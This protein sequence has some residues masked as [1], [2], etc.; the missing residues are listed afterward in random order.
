MNR[1]RPPNLVRA[2]SGQRA[3]LRPVRLFRLRHPLVQ[4]APQ[5]EMTQVPLQP[6]PSGQFYRVASP[7]EESL[8]TSPLATELGKALEQFAQSNGFSAEQPLSI[9]FKRGTLG[10]HRFGRAADIYAAGGKGIGQWASEWNAAMRQ[11]N[12]ATDPQERARLIEEEKQRNLGYKLYKA[13]QAHGG[14]AQPQSYP[15]QLFGPWTRGEGPHK[16]ISDRLLR[17]HGDHL[18]I[19]K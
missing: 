10:L 19:A 12:A 3:R 15:V 9:T 18:H 13:L 11:A 2:P 17:A 8:V 5:P 16:T 14:W 1:R 7:V 6:I 4:V